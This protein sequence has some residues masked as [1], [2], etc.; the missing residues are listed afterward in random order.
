MQTYEPT[1]ACRIETI[2]CSQPLIH[3]SKEKLRT[4]ALSIEDAA[5]Q[6]AG[7]VEPISVANLLLL[8][9]SITEAHG[10]L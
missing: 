9:Q 4:A 2:I 8:S 3:E 5:M 1:R 10:K 6:L 7:V